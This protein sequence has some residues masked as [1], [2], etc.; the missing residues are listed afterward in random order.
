[1]SMSPWLRVISPRAS[2]VP[3]PPT[4]YHSTGESDNK[5]VRSVNRV[6]IDSR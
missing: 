3:N 4:K 1:M 2:A 6:S 5:F